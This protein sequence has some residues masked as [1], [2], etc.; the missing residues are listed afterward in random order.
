MTNTVIKQII[1]VTKINFLSQEK[2]SCHGKIIIDTGLIFS[3]RNFLSLKKNISSIKITIYFIFVH[4]TQ[5]FG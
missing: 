4:K 3:E 2:I 1:A 5:G